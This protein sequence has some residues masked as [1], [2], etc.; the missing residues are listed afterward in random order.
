MFPVS[1]FKPVKF[2]WECITCIMN[3]AFLKLSAKN[4][5]WIEFEWSKSE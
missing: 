5:D 3:R 4:D 2:T 1:A